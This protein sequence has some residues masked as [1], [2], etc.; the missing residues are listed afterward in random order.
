MFFG[1]KNPKKDN[2][3]KCKVSTLVHLCCLDPFELLLKTSTMD[4]ANFNAC[5]DAMC[6]AFKLEFTNDVSNLVL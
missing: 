6:L 1:K 2:N 3:P 4:I 5:D